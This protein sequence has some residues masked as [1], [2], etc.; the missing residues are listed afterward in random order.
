MED[1][2]GMK[3]N[4]RKQIHRTV[5]CLALVLVF[6]HGICA[7]EN[8]LAAD[9]PAPD[10]RTLS[11][12]E[13]QML[14]TEFFNSGTDNMNNMLLTSEYDRPEEVDLF[15]T[16]YGGIGGAAGCVCTEETA[17]LTALDSQTPYLDI[18][19]ITA[20]E[21]DGFL[22]EKLGV[23]LEETQKK[24]LEN[25]YYL[26]QY[27]SYYLVKGDTN[28]DWCAVTAGSCQPDGTLVLEYTKANEGGRWIATLQKTDSGYQ[29][30]SNVR[31]IRL[32]TDEN[33]APESSTPEYKTGA[34]NTDILR[35][36]ETA[37]AG[38]A[39]VMHLKKGMEV[40]IL[41]SEN[42][43]F[44]IAVSVENQDEDLTGYVRKEFVSISQDLAD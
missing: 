30:V 32:G 8:T 13:L 44:H 37:D 43:F 33:F 6:L 39:V 16:F 9:M 24:G 40:K 22:S 4:S 15:Q 29:F 28:F 3:D 1:L 7:P 20:G 21:M 25:F 26:E 41:G 38:A 27:D 2:Y 18:V 10:V 12:A 14:N 23:G 35:V 42:I 19:K 36:R 31:Q 17:L 34:V 5:A 11:D